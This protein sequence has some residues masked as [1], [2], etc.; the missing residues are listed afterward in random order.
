MALQ[1]KVMAAK[2]DN[3]SSLSR[4]Y[5]VQGKNTSAVADVWRSEGPFTV[6][7]LD[8]LRPPCGSQ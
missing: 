3:L 1:I 6:L 4:I 2:P 5:A 8:S 7:V